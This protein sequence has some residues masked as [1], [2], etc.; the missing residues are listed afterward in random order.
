MTSKRNAGGRWRVLV[1][2]D[3]EAARYGIRRALGVGDYE[4]EEAGSVEEARAKMAERGPDLML[5][6]V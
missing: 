4:I 3:E 1:V 5:L 2:D 6:D